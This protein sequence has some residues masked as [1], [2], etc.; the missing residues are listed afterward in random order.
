MFIKDRYGCHAKSVV[1]VECHELASLPDHLCRGMC[2]FCFVGY[3]LFEVVS[4][5]TFVGVY[6]RQ[7]LASD[8]GAKHNTMI[9]ALTG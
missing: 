8:S 9:I 3:D 5:P 6:S 4:V 2:F 7:S 1:G